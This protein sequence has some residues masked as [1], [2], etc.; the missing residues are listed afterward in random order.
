M[1]NLFLILMG[2]NTIIES[3]AYIQFQYSY[4]SNFKAKLKISKA[5]DDGRFYV[6]EDL[7]WSL[8]I[9]LPRNSPH[10]RNISLPH[11]RSL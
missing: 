10:S 7:P 1:P 3:N 8:E 11:P 2:L 5:L 6:L 4:M 9:C